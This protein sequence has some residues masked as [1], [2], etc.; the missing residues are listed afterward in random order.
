[1]GAGSPPA[2]NTPAGCDFGE[3]GSGRAPATIRILST[4]LV[5]IGSVEAMSASCTIPERRGRPALASFPE[6]LRER[7]LSEGL[8]TAGLPWQTRQA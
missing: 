2:L 8:W 4:P 5:V 6:G 7:D 1:M 3:L